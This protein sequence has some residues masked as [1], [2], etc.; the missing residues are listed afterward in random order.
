MWKALDPYRWLI[1]GLLIAGALSAFG[2]YRYSLIQQ[3]HAEAIAEVQAKAT[4]QLQIAARQT[5]NMQEVKDEAIENAT[6][7]AKANA[8]AAAAA[9]SELGKLRQS[10]ASNPSVSG[11]SCAASVDRAAALG[12]VFGECSAAL[13]ELAE[14]AD[15]HANDAVMLHES[16]P[17]LDDFNNRLATFTDKLKGNT[18]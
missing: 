17:A 13:V 16:W 18:P 5:A 12:A 9:R 6:T 1:G 15:A 2:W 7:R 4:E 11:D 3:G 10:V 14:K 8:S